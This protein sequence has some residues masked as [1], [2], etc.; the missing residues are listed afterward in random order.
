MNRG[1][2]IV[3]KFTSGRFWCIILITITACYL[4]IHEPTIRD[5]FFALAGAII[6]DY[7][8]RTDRKESSEVKSKEPKEEP[9]G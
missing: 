1:D 2:T 4:A 3:S 5:A 8:M 6:R 7:F 9:N